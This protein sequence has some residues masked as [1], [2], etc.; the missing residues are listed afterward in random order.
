[1]DYEPHHAHSLL[2]AGAL[3]NRDPQDIP[4]NRRQVI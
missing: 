3:F 2:P 4:E 1:M